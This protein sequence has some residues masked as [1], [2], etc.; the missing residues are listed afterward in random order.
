MLIG[1]ES[2]VTEIWAHQLAVFLFTVQSQGVRTQPLSAHSHL[3]GSCIRL[4]KFIHLKIIHVSWAWTVLCY[5]YDGS[6]SP[7]RLHDRLDPAGKHPFLSF[8]IFP[9]PSGKLLS[10]VS[11]PFILAT[12]HFG[13]QVTIPHFSSS[14]LWWLTSSLGIS[15][16]PPLPLLLLLRRKLCWTGCSSIIKPFL[17]RLSSFL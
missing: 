1:R 4:R 13:I 5:Q 17:L 6:Y 12:S 11:P 3:S 9:S 2:W 15:T 8:P 7:I 10:F 16:L 14:L